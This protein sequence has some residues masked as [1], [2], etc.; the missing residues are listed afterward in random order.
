MRTLKVL[1]WEFLQNIPIF[2]GFAWAFDF[3][4]RGKPWIALALAV[5]GGTCGA[6]LISLT[7]SKKVPGHKES[8]P[9]LLT[10][11]LAITTFIFAMVVYFRTKGTT[12]QTDIILGIL[13]GAGLAGLQ[14]LAAKKKIDTR[15]CIALGFAS[16]LAII[17]IRILL[18]T[19]WSVWLDIFSITVL[20]TVIIGLIDYMPGIFRSG[21]AL[22]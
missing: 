13:G 18:N 14:S 17:G 12:W 2:T 9:V 4:T 5:A 19:G 21:E 22:K 15:H 16:T 7:E 10:N 20:A 3:L 1:F 11:I 6:I 8:L